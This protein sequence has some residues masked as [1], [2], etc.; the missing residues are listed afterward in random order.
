MAS[1]TITL[2][3]DDLDGSDASETI[4]FGLDGKAYEIDLSASNAAVLRQSLGKFV[5]VARKAGGPTLGA[6]PRRRSGSTNYD[7]ATVRA[8]AASQGI[9]VNPRGRISASVLEKYRAAGH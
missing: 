9:A 4:R 3:S 7:P 1:K 2:L 6:T 5:G 8:W